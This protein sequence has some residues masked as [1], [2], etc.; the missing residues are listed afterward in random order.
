MYLTYVKIC[1]MS[2]GSRTVKFGSLLSICRN[3]QTSYKLPDKSI[4]WVVLRIYSLHFYAQLRAIFIV[5][6]TKLIIATNVSII[7]EPYV[8]IFPKIAKLFRALWPRRATPTSRAEFRLSQVM[9]GNDIIIFITNT[10]ESRRS[11]CCR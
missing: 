4:T 6:L 9:W 1:V 2:R 3:L 7:C 8:I 11:P 10:N 5:I